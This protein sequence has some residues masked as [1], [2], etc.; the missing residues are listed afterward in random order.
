MKQNAE[1][2]EKWYQ[3][4]H[5]FEIY[6]YVHILSWRDASNLCAPVKRVKHFVRSLLVVYIMYIRG[7]FR[8]YKHGRNWLVEFMKME[9][10]GDRDDGA[11][12]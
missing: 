1:R 9:Q 8:N 11:H 12:Y 6:E 5:V 2:N 4:G 3:R 7:L 10:R